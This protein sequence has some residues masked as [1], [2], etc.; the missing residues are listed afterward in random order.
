MEKTNKRKA[1]AVALA[2][3]AVLV[4]AGTIAYL[5]DASGI[6]RNQ[7]DP[8]HVEVDI[9]ESGIEKDDGTKDYSI[10]PGATDEKDPHITV[11][12]DTDA[13]VFAAVKD[14]I[15]NID[16]TKYVDYEI[17]DGWTLLEPGDPSDMISQT[18]TKYINTFEDHKKTG[19]VTIDPNDD[20]TKIYYRVVHGTNDSQI[21]GPFSV[22]K[23]DQVHYPSTLT[24]ADLDKLTTLGED[25]KQLTFATYAIQMEPFCDPAETDETK[26]E[27]GAKDAWNQ[28]DKVSKITVTAEDDAT[29]VGVG[30]TLQMY[31]SVEP[32]TAKDKTVI[33]SVEPGTG[34]ATIDSNGVL[35]GGTSGTVIVVAT[36]NDGSGVKGTYEVTVTPKEPSNSYAVQI[37]QTIDKDEDGTIDTLDFGPATGVDATTPE[38]GGHL[39]DSDHCIHTDSWSAIQAHPENYIGC[40]TAGCTKG[41]E[42]SIPEDTTGTIWKPTA[43]E[44]KTTGDGFGVFDEELRSSARAWNSVGE[45]GSFSG[46]YEDADNIQNTLTE[47]LAAFPPEL[48][49]AITYKTISYTVTDNSGNKGGTFTVSKKLWLLNEDDLIAAGKITDASRVAY[50]TKCWN[51]YINP[52]GQTYT[53]RDGQT[54]IIPDGKKIYIDDAGLKYIVT[55]AGS[56]PV[57]F[58]LR[59]SFVR[60]DKWN[61]Y[62][63]ASDGHISDD[64]ASNTDVGVAPG[65][66]ISKSN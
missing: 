56:Y 61:V 25:Q 35:T 45:Y 55:P 12:T 39:C 18:I 29:E 66:R 52:D 53:D 43:K 37:Y 9:A 4:L 31:A 5:A 8:N 65:F 17:A 47:I 26:I 30:R 22:L 42:L 6:I 19:S 32:D 2:T 40:K 23:N 60:N 63:I 1:K 33:W 48:Q 41:V 64:G 3:A 50:A 20:N 58:T 62:T 54:H 21:H 51:E 57:W 59:D 44:R 28:V 46:K 13:F 49:D 36:A 14:N 24:N 15:N 38:G 27:A 10:I 34:T 11:D 16:G 7:W